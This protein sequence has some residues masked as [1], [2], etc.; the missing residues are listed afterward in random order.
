MRCLRLALV[1]AGCL[2]VPSW[3]LAQA[4]PGTEPLTGKEDF[5]KVMVEGTD[6]YLTKPTKANAA[7]RTESW[8]PDYSSAA[9]YAKSLEPQRRRL[10][11]I[12]G[13]IDERSPP[14]M[15]YVASIDRPALLGEL[16]E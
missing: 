7:K 9:A 10:R 3:G 15:E 1:V 4:L 6:R 2:A 8:K 16:K 12:L 14:A 13:V 11:Q 5:A